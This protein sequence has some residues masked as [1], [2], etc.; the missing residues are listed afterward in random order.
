M[1][2][3][4]I[5]TTLLLATTLSVAMAHGGGGR[6]PGAGMGHGGTTTPDTTPTDTS[7]LEP[8]DD[9]EVEELLFMRAEEKL[10]RD[11]YQTLYEQ[12]GARIFSNIA[13]SEQRHMDSMKALIDKYGLEDPV[14]D[15]TNGV[16][17]NADLAQMY[18]DL[19]ARG[20]TSLEEALRV[21]ALIEEVD[22]ADLDEAIIDSSHTDVVAAYENLEKGSRNH[23]RAFV[24]QL[25]SLGVVYEPAIMDLERFEAIV[26][27]P[28]ERGGANG[29][30]QDT[31]H[32]GQTDTHPR[33]LRCNRWG[34]RYF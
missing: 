20:M 31:G 3:T 5:F 29:T 18:G 7:V 17:K 10:A 11:V 13:R 6:G 25:E 32:R 8:L 26:D 30:G 22:I 12:W 4:K 14:T 24:R 15:D 19:V 28:T 9:L 16:F 2:K 27:S 23:L 34:C 21:G 1:K 33:I